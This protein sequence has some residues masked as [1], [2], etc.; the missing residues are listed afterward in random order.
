[1]TSL[2]SLQFVSLKYSSYRPSYVY[3]ANRNTVTI[4]WFWFLFLLICCIPII[5]YCLKKRAAR[6]HAEAEAEH[7][8]DEDYNKPAHEGTV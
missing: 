3:S 4:D 1:M 5:W 6:L 2:K 7:H 8:D